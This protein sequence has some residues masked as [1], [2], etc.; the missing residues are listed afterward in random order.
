MEFPVP[1]SPTGFFPLNSIGPVD[2]EGRTLW[3]S[4]HL[5][6]GTGDRI[7]ILFEKFT[8]RPRQGV[9][10]TMG[11]RR[12]EIAINGQ[13]SAQ[14]ILWADTAPAEVEVDITKAGRAGSLVIYNIWQDEKYGTILHG[15][16]WTAMAVRHGPDGSLL[17]DC[18]DGYGLEPSFGDLVLR[19]FHEPA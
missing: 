5:P 8:R 18:S 11:N 4:Y 14:F 1:G 2:F 16:N 6:V 13:Q 10:L 9:V 19:L 3:L 15:L 12:H 17:L 7:R